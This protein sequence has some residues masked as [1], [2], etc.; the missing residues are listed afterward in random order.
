MI[1][2]N[3]VTLVQA[4]KISELGEAYRNLNIDFDILTTTIGK[5]R[6]WSFLYYSTKILIDS[7][8]NSWEWEKD[9]SK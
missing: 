4:V 7:F 9:Q 3:N 6:W 8:K 5:K 1:K 2:E